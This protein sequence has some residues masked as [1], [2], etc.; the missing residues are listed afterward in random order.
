MVHNLLYVKVAKSIL[1]GIPAAKLDSRITHVGH[2][3]TVALITQ[4]HAVCVAVTAPPHGNA[5]AVHPTLELIYMAATWRT[6]CC[7]GNG[8]IKCDSYNKTRD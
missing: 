4:V 5:Q 7:R 1:T 2:T 8:K 6:G 3:L